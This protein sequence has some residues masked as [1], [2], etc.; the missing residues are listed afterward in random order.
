[1]RIVYEFKKFALRGSVIDL[2]VG[3]TVGAAFSTVATSLVN[4]LIMPPVGLAV[5]SVDFS[6][7]FVILRDGSLAP[8]PYAT[9]M[10]AREAGAVT[11]NYGLFITNVVTFMILALAMF[12]LVGLLA[13]LDDSLDLPFE[14]EAVAAETKLP[15]RPLQ[16]KCPYCLSAVAHAAT[17]CPH[18]TSHLDQRAQ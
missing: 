9:L 17:R 11:L 7:L 2:A 12:A 14:T 5:G 4:D 18:C 16:K 1:M 8:A 15:K 13:R 10:A 3:F 6:N